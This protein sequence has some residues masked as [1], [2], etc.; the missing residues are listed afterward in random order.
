MTATTKGS[1]TVTLPADNQILITR[2]FNAPAR[3]VW[4]AY[5]TPELIRRW[6]AGQRGTV[7][8]VEVDLRVGGRW[9]YVMT[10]NPGFEVAFHGE[11]REIQE[12]VRLV[13]TEAFEGIPD[14]DGNAALVT[15]TLTEKD[16]RTAMEMLVE[17]RDQ[18]GRDA[19]V[20]SGME[21]G[22]QEAMDALEELAASLA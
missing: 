15:M 16:G 13:N 4:K 14:P 1:A 20:N 7:T 2:E 10:A 8:S 12:P 22:M 6:W 17:H 9:R 19:H 18:E 3:L 21:G 5:T 11:Y